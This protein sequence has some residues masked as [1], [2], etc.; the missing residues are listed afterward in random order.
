[1]VVLLTPMTELM[2]FAGDQIKAPSPLR[3]FQSERD[4]SPLNS[5]DGIKRL[6][7]AVGIGKS[8]A[9]WCFR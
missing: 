8:F 2:G 5:T 1:M 9:G 4:E 7:P 6:K 3:G